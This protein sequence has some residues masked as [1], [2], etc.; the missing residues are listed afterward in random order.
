[1]DVVQKVEIKIMIFFHGF[2][3]NFIHIKTTE[4]QLKEC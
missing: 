2:L 4:N 1:M 3:G